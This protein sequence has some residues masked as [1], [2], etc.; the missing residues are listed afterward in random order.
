MRQQHKRLRKTEEFLKDL[1]M[2][3][4]MVKDLLGVIK[5]LQDHLCT[6]HQVISEQ[7][8]SCHNCGQYTIKQD[9]V[10]KELTLL[11]HE[12]QRMIQ[13]NRRISVSGIPADRIYNLATRTY[14]VCE[15]HAEMHMQSRNR[16][17]S[18]Q[19]SEDSA[20]SDDNEIMEG[21]LMVSNALTVDLNISFQ[22]KAGKLFRIMFIHKNTYLPVVNDAVKNGHA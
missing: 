7:K 2:K 19:H 14:S 17:S 8:F 12:L 18:C 22:L 5:Q 16:R 3:R 20:D 6:Q 15:E 11:H 4:N 13:S 21:P 1:E 10:Q 9:L